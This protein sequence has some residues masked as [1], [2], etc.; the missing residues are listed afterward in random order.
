M[1]IPAKRSISF[2]DI[3]QTELTFNADQCF[4]NIRYG[5]SNRKFTSCVES[6]DSYVDF[7]CLPLSVTLTTTDGKVDHV[8]G[9]A[10]NALDNVCR[11]LK[12]Q[13]QIDGQP[14]TSL[15]VKNAQGKPLRV[16]SPN[17]ATVMGGNIFKDYM[18]NYVDQVYDNYT[19]QALNCDTQAQWG[20]VKGIVTNS[21]LK[22]ENETFS[23]PG[24]EDI[25]SCCTGPFGN[26]LTPE[27][28]AI[29]PRLSAAFNRG[30]LLNSNVTPD[31]FGPT[32]YYKNSI[33][34]HYS[35]IVHEQCLDGRG[36][37]FPYDDVCQDG[38]PDQCGAVYDAKPKKLSI[39]V[40][41]NSAYVSEDA[42][43]RPIYN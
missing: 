9:M 24:T 4:A 31:P 3:F 34:N 11:A 23:K 35:R 42:Y 14:W 37:A 21:V 5:L 26:D 19:T 15:I 43:G 22:F 40:G 29:I 17:N 10:T 25:F 30:T 2:A 1:A 27:K 12:A 33:C 39:A 36:Y 20:R 18:E 38:G 8:S 16:L 32:T 6:F 7:V 13:G 41:G 28:L